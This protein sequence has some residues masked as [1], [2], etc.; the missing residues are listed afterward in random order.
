MSETAEVPNTFEESYTKLIAA[1]KLQIGK[2]GPIRY[3][4]ASSWIK[5]TDAPG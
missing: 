3:E 5:P 2:K 1:V 4:G